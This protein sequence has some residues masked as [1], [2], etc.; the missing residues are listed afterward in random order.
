MKS[1]PTALFA[2]AI[3][4]AMAIVF[5]AYSPAISQ[6]RGAGFMMAAGTSDIAWKVNTVTGASSFCIRRNNSVDPEYIAN[7]PPVCSAWSPPAE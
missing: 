6:Q 5:A 2:S 3:V 1:W 7:N 4:I